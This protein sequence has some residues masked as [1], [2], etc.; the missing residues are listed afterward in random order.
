MK[1]IPFD[2][3][4]QRRF[5]LA[6]ESAQFGHNLHCLH[7]E[8]SAIQNVPVEDCDHCANAQ[9]D[10]SLCWEHMSEVTFSDVANKI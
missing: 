5:K 6:C 3:S 10:M 9:A 2:M 8:S 1:N 4:A 7:E